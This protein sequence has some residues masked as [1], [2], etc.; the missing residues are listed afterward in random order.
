MIWWVGRRGRLRRA[1][2]HAHQ[3]ILLTDVD[4]SAVDSRWPGNQVTLGYD[5]FP[6]LA[7]LLCNQLHLATQN[8]ENLFNVV[9]NV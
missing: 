1:Q 8:K 3:R 4:F 9:M 2:H 7:I 5:D 6:A